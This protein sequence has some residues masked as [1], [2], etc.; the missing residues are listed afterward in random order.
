MDSTLQRVFVANGEIQAQQVRA[1]LEAAGIPAAKRG[2]SLRNT[3]GLTL[4]GLGT[5][6]IL[7]AAADAER[8]RSLL[9]AADAGAFRLTDDIEPS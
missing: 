7:V 9:D 4:D 8:A 3:H 1:F 2:E 5:V 6:E